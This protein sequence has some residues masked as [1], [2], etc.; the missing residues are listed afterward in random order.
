MSQ[1]HDIND[2]MGDSE[3]TISCNEIHPHFLT[4]NCLLYV[5]SGLII[6]PYITDSGFESQCIERGRRFQRTTRYGEGG[7]GREGVTGHFARTANTCTED[8]S[9][10]SETSSPKQVQKLPEPENDKVM[11]TKGKEGTKSVS[12]VGML[13]RERLV[14]VSEPLD[15]AMQQLEESLQDGER[16]GLGGEWWQ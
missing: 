8:L 2:I 1:S 15:R 10:D 5:M 9:L 12:A 11:E 3:S 7:E 4:F 14:S 16:E 6:S 13:P